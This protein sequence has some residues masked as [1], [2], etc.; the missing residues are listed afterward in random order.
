[1]ESRNKRWKLRFFLVLWLACLPGAALLVFHQVPEAIGNLL[2]PLP[3]PLGV[4]VLSALGQTALLFGLMIG[5]GVLSA[6][7][8]GLK[9]PAFEA[10]AKG[11]SVLAAMRPQWVPGALGGL[12][13]G[14]ATLWVGRLLM[15]PALA[16]AS[17][18]V[19][20][21]PLPIRLL[22]GGITEELL[23]RWSVMSVLLW[24][25]WRIF[26]RGRGTPAVLAVWIAILGSAALFG[27]G[28]LPYLRSITG[29][30]DAQ[31][32][33]YVMMGNGL[34]AVVAGVLFRR[35]GLEAAMLAHMLFHLLV[36]AAES[37][38]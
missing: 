24:L 14:L 38:A 31:S 33:V 9:A 22:Y 35:V 8:I 4:V 23:L 36:F 25:I 32:V 19:A 21:M 11:T 7:R 17:E 12:I 37:L 30:L 28:H 10:W 15:P 26:Q 16:A 2:E 13:G 1:M 29:A 18:D 20:P 34:F 5:L 27:A 3:L 6:G